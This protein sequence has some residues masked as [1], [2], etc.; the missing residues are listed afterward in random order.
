MHP[1]EKVE[2]GGGVGGWVQCVVIFTSP[3]NKGEH[4][5]ASAAGG[6]SQVMR[7]RECNLG[8]GSLCL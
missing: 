4:I 5:Q 2:H 1:E 7:W 3:L 8:K 6:D